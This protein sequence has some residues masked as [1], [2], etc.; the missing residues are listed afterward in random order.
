VEDPD[1]READ[2]LATAVVDS[3][4]KH[5]TE[6]HISRQINNAASQLVDSIQAS[7]MPGAADQPAQSRRETLVPR[8]QSAAADV[9]SS[10]AMSCEEPNGSTQQES[11]LP[12]PSSA[13]VQTA[14]SPPE[15]LQNDAHRNYAHRFGSDRKAEAAASSIPSHAVDPH[16]PHK[17]R[18]RPLR[19]RVPGA[20][21]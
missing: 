12:R 18:V 9:A 10:S 21:Q 14:V 20:G 17:Q 16:S 15:S 19:V 11:E 1:T 7:L 4:S 5:L 8:R 2:G 6:T 13:T 3:H